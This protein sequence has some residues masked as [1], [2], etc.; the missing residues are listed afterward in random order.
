M[1][2]LVRDT[3]SCL[4]I[5]PGPDLL[6]FWF[7]AYNNH[8]FRCGNSVYGVV[9]VFHGCIAGFSDCLFFYCSL[10]LGHRVKTMSCTTIFGSDC[11]DFVSA[12]T[13][14]PQS[15]HTNPSAPISIY[16]HPSNP[17]FQYTRLRAVFVVRDRTCKT[18]PDHRFLPRFSWFSCSPTQ[19]QPTAPM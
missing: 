7:W 12:R 5:F 11:L 14:A 9:T 3:C 4:A 15:T 8:Y 17:K 19:I 2:V 6:I 1:H 16:L 10:L 18:C 13:P